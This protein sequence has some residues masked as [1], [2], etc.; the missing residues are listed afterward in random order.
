M[1]TQFAKKKRTAQ[2][3]S[4]FSGDGLQAVMERENDYTVDKLITFFAAL[5]DGSIGSMESCVLNWM[6][7]LYTAVVHKVL[8]DQ[9]RVRW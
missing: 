5:I 8:F 3:N 4:L 7:L 1:H 9:K 6:S 2:L